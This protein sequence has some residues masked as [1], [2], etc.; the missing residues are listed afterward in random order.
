[1]T[2]ASLSSIQVPCNLYITNCWLLLSQHRWSSKRLVFHLK[3]IL[4]CTSVITFFGRT[5]VRHRYSWTWSPST[6]IQSVQLENELCQHNTHFLAF[7]H[8]LFF[9]WMV[10]C[11]SLQFKLPSQETARDL[12]D[13][14]V[15]GEYKNP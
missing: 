15:G 5:Q 7:P 3:I 1:M 8:E 11:C 13:W 4:L 9:P 2:K 6:H 10:R 12:D 14:R